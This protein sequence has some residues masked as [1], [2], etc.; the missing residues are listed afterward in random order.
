MNRDSTLMNDVVLRSVASFKCTAFVAAHIKTA[1]Y[2]FV[3]VCDLT[4][5][6][7]MSNGPQK[8]TAVRSK[9]G[10]GVT[11]CIGKAAIRCS[12]AFG[13]WRK[14]TKHF[15]RCDFTKYRARVIQ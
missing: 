7:L 4:P 15:P 11:R 13:R 9:G 3:V 12:R 6:T 2:P 14:Q 5:P 1:T 10:F 8:S